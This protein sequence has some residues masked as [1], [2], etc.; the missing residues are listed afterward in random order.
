MVPNDLPMEFNGGGLG[1]GGLTTPIDTT[2]I[3]Q[4]LFM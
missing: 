2:G 3:L 1:T 4:A